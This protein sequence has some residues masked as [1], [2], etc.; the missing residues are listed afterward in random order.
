MRLQLSRIRRGLTVG[1]LA[2]LVLGCGPQAPFVL[3]PSPATL[4]YGRVYVGTTKGLF[5]TTRW[6]NTSSAA[7]T[8]NGI[9]VVPTGSP[10]SVGLTQPFTPITLNPDEETPSIRFNFSPT[11]A[12]PASAEGMLVQA[13]GAA[14]NVALT[15]EGVFQIS[16]GG[17]EVGDRALVAGQALDFGDVPFP[18]GRS[19]RE[20]RLTNRTNEMIGVLSYFSDGKQ[21]FKLVAP[22]PPFVLAA[23]ESVV[24]AVLFS[25]PDTGSFSDAITFYD[26]T[27]TRQAGT[28]LK[29]RGVPRD[30]S[31]GGGEG[32]GQ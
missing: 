2:G 13:A 20:F 15:G 31:N 11:A 24:I 3:E 28:A 9:G 23:S 8:I 1:L 5:S 16:D 7:I 19:L 18:G 17:F 4:D 27:R 12:G 26:P 10:F 32:E 22:T 30:E 25:P 14:R 21:G 6:K 29:G